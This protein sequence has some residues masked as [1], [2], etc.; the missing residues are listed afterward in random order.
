M[1][2]DNRKDQRKQKL[3]EKT[4]KK[5]FVSDEQKFASKVKKQF[6][7]QQQDMRADELWEDW[8]NEVY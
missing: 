8:E 3:E 7:R 6:K 4:V 1:T 2:E 5:Q